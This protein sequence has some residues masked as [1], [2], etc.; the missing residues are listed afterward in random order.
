MATARIDGGAR[1]AIAAIAAIAAAALA[2]AAGCRSAARPAQR[3]AAA[4]RPPSVEEPKGPF[5]DSLDLGFEKDGD[6]HMDGGELDRSTRRFGRRSARLRPGTRR[7][8]VAASSC[9]AG[10]RPR[11]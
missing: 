6:W 2:T 9:A 10:S 11:R 1:I 3:A 4:S 7:M 5:V 8:A